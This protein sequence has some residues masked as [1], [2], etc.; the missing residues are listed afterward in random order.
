[1]VCVISNL[2][3]T[4]VRDLRR[5]QPIGLTT[6]IQIQYNMFDEFSEKKIGR[7]FLISSKMVKDGVTRDQKYIPFQTYRLVE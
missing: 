1:M 2:Y 3:Y 7:D 4:T 6:R 5:I